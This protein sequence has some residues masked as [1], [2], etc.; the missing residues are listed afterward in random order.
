MDGW[1]MSFLLGWP[2]FRCYVSFREGI[3]LPFSKHQ[4][5]KQ[6]QAPYDMSDSVLPG[7][8]GRDWM[9]Q[10]WTVVHIGFTYDWCTKS[11]TI[12]CLTGGF[13]QRNWELRWY[14]HAA[15][16]IGADW[17]LQSRDY[18]NWWVRFVGNEGDVSQWHSLKPPGL[19]QVFQRN[20]FWF[21]P[22]ENWNMKVN[23]NNYSIPFT[24]TSPENWRE[25]SQ[26]SS[27]HHGD[28]FLI[29]RGF[30]HH[31]QGGCRRQV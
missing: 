10:V 20:S 17:M 24:V 27:S 18:L 2:V 28:S 29:R 3:C 21:I 5:A 12:V 23:M 9:H 31:R 13:C 14:H 19:R 22:P 4:T 1:K 15:C 25:F 8:E 7:S 6:I 30:S 16:F 26:A 11:Q